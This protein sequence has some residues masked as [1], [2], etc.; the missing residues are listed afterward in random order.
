MEDTQKNVTMSAGLP[1]D[2]ERTKKFLQVLQ[3]YRSGKKRTEQRILASENWWKLRN[4]IEE[5]KQDASTNVGFKSK[6]GWLHNVIVSKHADAVKAYPEPNILPREKADKAEAQK[7]RAIIPCVLEQNKFEATYS[8]VMWQKLKT[9]TGAYKVVWD[10][11]KLNGMGDISIEKVSLLNLYWE[12]GVTDIQKS[13][14]IFHTELRDKELLQAE[15]PELAGKLKGTTFVSTKFLYDDAVNETDK[16]TV[17]DVYYHTMVGTQKVLQ[18][19]KFVDDVVLY[20]TENDPEKAQRGLYDHGK[21][22]FV[23]DP[24]YPI[25]GSPCGYGFVDVCR[26]PQTAIDVLNTAMLKNARAGAI[27]KYLGKVDGGVNLEDLLDMD[28]CIIP[29]NGSLDENHL[30]KVDHN[31][32]DGNYMAFLDRFVQELRETSGNTEAST[33]SAPAGVTA[34]SAIAALQEAAGKG[35]V[36]STMGSYRAYNDI[37]ELVIELIRQFYDLPRQF[38]ITGQYGEEQFTEYTNAGIKGIPQYGLGGQQIGMRLPVFDIKVSAQKKSVYNKV[39][40][41]ELALQFFQLGFF[42]P[43]MAEQAMMCLE[44]MDFDDKDV[45]MQMISKNA[46]MQQKLIQYMQLAL[47]FAQAT[48]PDMVQG[49][50]QDIMKTLGAEAPMATAVDP[51]LMQSDEL[52]GMKG[53][54]HG[55]VRNARANAEAATQPDGGEVVEER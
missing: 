1:V 10:G 40:Q 8:D 2:A 7:L 50:S 5:A 24:L 47:T 37:V 52:G 41:N 34:A 9:G 36:A 27:P 42:N 6:S 17:I 45:I 46:T 13:R 16:S 23:L 15:Y 19:C 30:R 21:F 31:P 28:K 12:P 35:S 48:R 29:V 54:E 4:D 11:K 53:K 44:M 43:Q 18:Y 33:G 32:L 38:R 22:P 3:D 39:S 55:V 25:E 26:N 14:Y 51:Q 20:A 49:I